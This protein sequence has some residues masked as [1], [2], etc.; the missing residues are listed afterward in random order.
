M[1]L[2]PN[3]D[4]EVFEKKYGISLTSSASTLGIA[5]PN[6]PEPIIRIIDISI[7]DVTPS[8]LDCYTND[9]SLKSLENKACKAFVTPVTLATPKNDNIQDYII[10]QLEERVAII[11]HDGQIPYDWALPIAKIQLRAKPESITNE[12]WKII[13]QTFRNADLLFAGYNL[14]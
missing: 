9:N 14:L 13:I 2:F 10:E 4:F 12:K 5:I 11:E 1:S 3:F 8:L 7:E 6:D